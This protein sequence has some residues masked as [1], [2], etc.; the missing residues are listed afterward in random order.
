MTTTK[1]LIKTRLH[2][3]IYKDLGGGRWETRAEYSYGPRNLVRAYRELIA[4]RERNCRNYGNIG[5]GV[6][7]MSTSD[8]RTLDSRLVMDDHKQSHDELVKEIEGALMTNEQHDAMD[9]AVAADLDRYEASH[10]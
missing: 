9:R 8:G 4:T 2:D 6:T 3:G 1:I 5:C 7:I 10:A